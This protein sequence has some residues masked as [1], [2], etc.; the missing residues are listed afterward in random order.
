LIDSTYAVQS[1]TDEEIP[2][3]ERSELIVPLYGDNV[4]F[5]QIEVERTQG[6]NTDIYLFHPAIMEYERPLARLSVSD[7]RAARLLDGVYSVRSWSD[8]EI[9]AGMSLNERG[10][11][12]VPL[13]GDYVVF[14]QIEVDR[15][16]R[17]NSG[18]YLFRF[19]DSLDPFAY[20]PSSS[21]ETVASVYVSDRY[22][23]SL[24]CASLL[25]MKRGDRL[26]LRFDDAIKPSYSALAPALRLFVYHVHPSSF[27]FD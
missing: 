25:A 17:N 12:I 8:V 1:W 14:A 2:L 20:Y 27:W 9:R 10:E 11:L 6:N 7:E 19:S 13:Y 24:N 4:V 26:A 3:N 15:N 22:R 18:I 21:I 16:Q 5:A 23:G